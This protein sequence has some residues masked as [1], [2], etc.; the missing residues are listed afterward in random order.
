MTKNAKKEDSMSKTR[1]KNFD[2]GDETEVKDPITFTIKGEEFTAIPEI[3]GTVLMDLVKR[4]ST[5][6]PAESFDM[7]IDLFDNAL[8]EESLVRF[9]ALIKDKKRIVTVEKLA[10][11]VAFLIEEYADRPEELR[12]D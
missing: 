5:E 6:D 3:Q 8:E 11:I 4:S 7:M 12:E 10:E 1:N 2:E 9:H